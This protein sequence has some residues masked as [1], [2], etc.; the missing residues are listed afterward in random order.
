MKTS[1]LILGMLGAVALVTSWNAVSVDAFPE[2]Y[3]YLIDSRGVLVRNSYGECWHAGFWTP[4]MAIAEC[5]PG[6]VQKPKLAVVPPLPAPLPA[7]SREI[8]KPVV[9]PTPP[10]V[11]EQAA[12]EKEPV[13]LLPA[14]VAVVPRETPPVVVAR[15]AFDEL[16][17]TSAGPAVA[18]HFDAET[19]FDFDQ[20]VVKPAGQK[21]LDEKIVAAMKM[22]PEVAQLIITGYADRIGTAAY[23]Q[24]LSERRAHAVKAYL[25]KQGI[26]AERMRTIGKGESEPNPQA[27]TM[28]ACK[29]MAGDKLIACLQ[30]DRSVTIESQR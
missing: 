27:N 19:L 9:A 13:Q 10:V 20:A 29:G 4:D 5:D 2:K 26:A 12:A 3:G 11:E 28:K 8:E 16:P 6:L 24:D 7:V 30:P 22:H 17:A 14:P 15:S 25:V 23:N 1:R 21:I 18:A